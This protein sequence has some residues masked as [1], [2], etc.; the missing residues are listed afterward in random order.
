MELL[1]IAIVLALALVVLGPERMPEV[2]RLLAKV[3]R[4]LRLASNT[5]LRELTD[6]FE[7]DRPEVPDVAKPLIDD[8]R[9]AEPPPPAP[10]SEKP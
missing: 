1:E 6:A 8:G 5:V 3:M 10:P 7:E 4:E 9:K 2:V